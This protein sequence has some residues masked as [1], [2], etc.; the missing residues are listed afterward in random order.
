MP[1]QLP[2]HVVVSLLRQCFVTPTCQASHGHRHAM[3]S[4]ST[5]SLDLIRSSRLQQFRHARK[6]Q[7]CYHNS[8]EALDNLRLHG[9]NDSS[10][11][12]SGPVQEHQSPLILADSH[13]SDYRQGRQPSTTEI[14]VLGGGITGLATAHYLTK[15][16]P[17]AKITIYEGSGRLGGW[18][19]SKAVNVANGQILFEEGPRTLRPSTP[20]AFVTL[21][22]VSRVTRL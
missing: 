16:L 3:S 18:L 9:K 8:K 14:A 22:M 15:Q 21:E 12:S 5:R 11:V 7:R 4:S 20:A 6:Q 13:N 2:E 19:K 17:N 10:T 1:S